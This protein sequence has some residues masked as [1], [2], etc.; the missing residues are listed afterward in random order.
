MRILQVFPTC[1]LPCKTGSLLKANAILLLVLC[2]PL[3]PTI[4]CYY[5]QNMSAFK[6]SFG[7]C[8]HAAR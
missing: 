4:S 3:T 1:L 8:L 2:L 5:A 7:S 6:H